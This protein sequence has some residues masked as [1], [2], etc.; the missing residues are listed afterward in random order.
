MT[1]E[2]GH[3]GVMRSDLFARNLV[4]WLQCNTD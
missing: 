2:G 4:H 1:L 3:M